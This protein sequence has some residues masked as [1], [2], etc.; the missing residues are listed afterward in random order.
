[1]WMY[2]KKLKRDVFC[3]KVDSL[4]EGYSI[5]HWSKTG[6]YKVSFFNPEKSKWS[7]ASLEAFEPPKEQ[8]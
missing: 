8:H 2:N 3:A 5:R 1:M 7:I 4:F 6:N